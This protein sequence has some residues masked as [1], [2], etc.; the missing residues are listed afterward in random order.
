MLRDETIR[1]V[2]QFRDDREWRQFHTPKDL[3]ISL[4]LEAAELLEIFQWSGANLECRDKLGRIR[5]ELADVLSYCVLMADV[6]GLDL[7]EILN[8]KVDQNAAKYPVEEAVKKSCQRTFQALRIDVNSEF[9]VLYAFL[10]KLPHVLKP[11]GRAAIL[12]FHSGED[13]LVKQAFRQQY[14]DGLYSDIAQEV[15]RPSPQ[16]CRRNPRAHSTKLRWA[17]RAE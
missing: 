6:C 2:I 11:G 10:D 12:T 3:A 7:D 1:R 5:E 16:E 9:E 15:T 14:R 17:V 8:A 4:S 13:R